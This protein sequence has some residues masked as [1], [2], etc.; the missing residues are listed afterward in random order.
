MQ[1]HPAKPNTVTMRLT[2][3]VPR[4]F[5]I[6]EVYFNYEN[7]QINTIKKPILYI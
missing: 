1:E 2:L 4:V 6:H 7:K 5:L 3:Q